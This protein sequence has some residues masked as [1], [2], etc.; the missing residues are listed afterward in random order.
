MIIIKENKR[1]KANERVA[2]KTLFFANRT[3]R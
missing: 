1:K 3:D 2:T